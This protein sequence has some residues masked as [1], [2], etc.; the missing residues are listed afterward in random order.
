[1]CGIVGVTEGTG[2]CVGETGRGVWVA[3]GFFGVSVEDAVRVGS[4]VKVREGRFSSTLR[5]SGGSVAVSGAPSP[6]VESG[7]GSVGIAWQEEASVN[8]KINPVESSPFFME[9]LFSM[10]LKSFI[11]RSSFL[12]ERDV[13]FPFRQTH[14]AQ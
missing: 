6:I 1:M 13:Y 11:H 10:C 7:G 9:I 3:V 4:S 14:T 2:E 12:Q 5:V 8:S